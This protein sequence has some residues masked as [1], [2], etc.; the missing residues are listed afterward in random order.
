M[1]P[2]PI[3]E[4]TAI[5]KQ[6]TEYN[7]IDGEKASTIEAI[8]NPVNTIISKKFGLNLSPS[9]PPTGRNNVH[10]TINRAVRTPESTVL[11][12]K[13]ETKKLGKNTVK[14]TKEPKVIK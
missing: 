7:P 13:F 10:N 14:A 9:K 8:V 3:P 5:D 6:P 4:H 11:N 2:L 12:P 1:T